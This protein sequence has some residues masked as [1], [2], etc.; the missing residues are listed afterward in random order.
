[1]QLFLSPN[2][3]IDQGTYW[4][5]VLILFVISALLSVASAYVS[6]MISF[7][8]I[9][10]VW[11]W[12]AVHVKR[13]HDAGKTGWLTIAMVVLAIVVSAIAS[14]VL[15]PLLG[16]DVEALQAEMTDEIMNIG[17]DAAAMMQVTMEY[18][19]KI[20]QAQ[21]IPSILSTGIV[22]GVVGVV[23]GLFKSDP[24]PNQYDIGGGGPTMTDS[25]F[26]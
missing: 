18:T 13:F 8:G 14:M 15:T 5:G 16:G 22:T 12:I 9:L 20:S 1:M 26:S 2:G 19:K 21:L 10:F 11:P 24:A 3:R 23:M 4:R 25:T 6:V 7:L 17:D